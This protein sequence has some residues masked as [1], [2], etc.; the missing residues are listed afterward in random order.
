M[1]ENPNAFELIWESRHRRLQA[2]VLRV[3]S[4]HSGG[5]YL[6]GEGVVLRTAR[7]G[8]SG[9]FVPVPVRLSG[10]FRPKVCLYWRLYPYG[11]VTD[12]RIDKDDDNDKGDNKDDDNDDDD[13]DEDFCN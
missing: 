12:I 13:N 8:V 3:G 5:D 4:Q 6:F 1:M 11:A 2:T 10:V 7:Y 9:S